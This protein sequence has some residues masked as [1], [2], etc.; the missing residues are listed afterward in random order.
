MVV[1]SNDDLNRL[2][3]MLPE[4]AKQSAYDYLTYLALIHRDRLLQCPVSVA[5]LHLS[6][7]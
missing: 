6:G 4:E 3:E 2:V 1:I 5:F 7:V